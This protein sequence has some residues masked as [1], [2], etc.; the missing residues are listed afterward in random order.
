MPSARICLTLIVATAAIGC[1]PHGPFVK[2]ESE[3]NCPTDIRKT[4][5]WCYGE[6][7]I[8]TCPCGPDEIY[9]GMKPTCWRPWD[10]S[11]ATWRD[12]YCQGGQCPGG[13]PVSGDGL[14][15]GSQEFVSP[16]PPVTAPPRPHFDAP[17]VL[18]EPGP[19]ARPQETIP[20]PR[21]NQGSATSGG[22]P[23]VRG[24]KLL[25]TTS[26]RRRTRRAEVEQ[27]AYAG[28]GAGS[29][30]SVAAADYC[31]SASGRD[32]ASSVVYDAPEDTSADRRPVDATSTRTSDDPTAAIEETSAARGQRSSPV[33][34]DAAPCW[35]IEFIR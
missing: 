5:P 13:C 29:G 19:A 4:V 25:P 35:P 14:P 6:D 24:I 32:V 20:A 10:S 23:A 22:R 17:P 2:R 1:R 8:F 26:Q 34:V 33:D 27:V 16:L 15:I 11:A 21:D 3:L 12:S 28:E 7:A 18:D 30:D 31:S 9:H